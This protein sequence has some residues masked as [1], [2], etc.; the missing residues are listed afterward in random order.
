MKKFSRM[1]KSEGGGGGGAAG[2]AAGG[3]GAGSSSGSSSVG[4]RVFAVG[5]YQ[6]TLEESL[7]EGGFST[8]FLVRTHGGI[9]HALKRMYV[10]NMPDLNICKREIT[11]MKELSGHKNIVSY[12]DC[13][14]NSISD[15]VW[16]VLI[17][18]EYC[19][20]GQ[21]VNQ[22]NKKLQTGFTE[23]EVLQIFCDTCEAVARLHQCKTPIIHRDLKV[24]N[25]LLNDSGNYVLCDF[26]SATN[27]FLN[28]QKDGV[29]L[30]EEEIKKAPEMIN[31]YGGKPITTKA[32]IWALGCLLYKLCF[33]TLPF[34]ESQVAICDGSF[35]IP[36]NSRYSQN[37]HCLIRFMLEPDPEHRPDIFQVSYFAFKFAKKECPVSNINNSSVPS[38]L[39]EPMTA[40]EAASRKS[41]I[42]ARITDTIGPTET[43]I[44]PRQRPKA[45][46]TTAT[47]SVLTI[48]SSATPVKVPAPGEFSNHRP[49]GALRPGSG[50]EIVL[51][52][53]PPQQPPQ[54][55]RVLQQLQQG[56]W[57][58]QQLHL[59][60]RAPPQP[61]QPQLL[62][63][64]YTQQYQQAMQQQQILQQQFLMHSVYQPQ[65]CASQYPTMMQ[66]YQQAF[67]QQQMLAQRQ[68]SQQ[69]ASPEY[70]TSPQEFPPALVPYASSLPA[71]VATVA[72]SSY[73]ANRSV[74]DKEAV[75]NIT[76]QKN[77]SNP[78]DM[79]GWNPFGEDNFSKLTEEE[80][81][82]REF[83]LLRSN[84]LEESASSDKNVDPLSAPHNH[85]PE[86][87]FGSV[88]FIS[89]SG[90]PEKKI[91]H[92]SMNQENSSAN[93]IKNRKASPVSKDHRTSKKTSENSSVQG[94]VQKR[95]DES[96]SDFES[97]PPSPKSS[98][99]EE[100]EDEEVLQGEQ[101]DF[102]D[103]DTEPENLG[104]RPL[105]MDSEDEEEEK[106]S[107]DSD[108]EQAKVKYS[109]VSPVYSRD[110]SGS[111]PAQD[112]TNT[113][114]SPPP[115]DV[116]VR[117]PQQEF[118]VFGA[119]PFFAVRAQQ[120]H[121]GKNEKNFCQQ[122]LRP[123]VGLEPE[124]FDV[125]T[126][127]PFSKK[128]NA[129]DGR[130]VGPEAHTVPGCPKSVDMFGSTPFQ[131]FPTSTSKSDSNEDLFGLVP[132]EEI[133]GSQQQK[134]KQRS[135]Q[136]L[137]S[138]QRRTKQDLSKSNGKRHHGTPTSTKKTGKPTYR[139]PERARRHK[140]VGR[141]DS[142]SSNEFLTISDSK[143][144]ISVA[145]TDGKDRG[146]GLQPEESLLDPFGA[147]PFHPPDLPWHPP[148]QGLGDIRADH[149]PVLPGRPRP[150]S[151]HGSFHSTDALKMDDFGAVPFTE[152]VVQSIT[153]HQPQ[154]S[155]SVELDP[156]GAAPF[157]SKQ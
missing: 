75:A 113:P 33:F 134:V 112:P 50:P 21:V 135:L 119:V 68:Q 155:Q 25:I 84:R 140:K 123:A 46:S 126:K 99:E 103:D 139:T 89:H 145:L 45:N 41:Q 12:L 106:H 36:D 93:P 90:S 117:A 7:A 100:Q 108:Y 80:L 74:A 136:K 42:K 70:L 48:Q 20:A 54:Q 146:N 1:P 4:V 125:F 130:A 16:E 141:R 104:H 53:G 96:E 44:A 154:Q 120:P 69:Q 15:N 67:L 150:N 87:P 83:D 88:P 102:N 143:E 133:T 118:D 30:V 76:S 28:P 23:A 38:A 85:P 3:A 131:P 110:K 34:G 9:R 39:P 35:T 111:G 98:E 147:K 65:P 156:F 29:N 116:G 59:Q 148:H 49:K 56:D 138:R 94:Q 128:A 144:N 101:G 22:M 18:M 51:G 62:P 40:S 124:E 115:S 55:H 121:Q 129:Q 52:Q 78:P 157:P 26:G 82:D 61:P 32:D 153:S 107:S 63:D 47:P 27:K 57:R 152:L 71:Q 64:A 137:S 10:N 5:R 142:Q 14:V 17:L 19:R 8:V 86:D 37:I 92:S 114:L 105:L 91:E 97:D 13:A 79:S 132:F 72:D 11:I 81:L 43:S 122:T 2:G 77:I 109:D 58:L 149:N 95:N 73:S 24:E 6:V 127:A 151:L 66:Q 31:L 60:P